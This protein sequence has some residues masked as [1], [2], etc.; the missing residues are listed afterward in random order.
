MATAILEGAGGRSAP[1]RNTGRR[2]V[3]RLVA[4]DARRHV[5]RCDPCRVGLDDAGLA[6]FGADGEARECVGWRAFFV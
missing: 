2:L 3:A 5:R 6:T 4:Q 1:A